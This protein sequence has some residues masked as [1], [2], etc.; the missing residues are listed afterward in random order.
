MLKRKVKIARNFQHDYAGNVCLK[1][2]LLGRKK[3][4]ANSFTDLHC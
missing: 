2:T 4:I 3:W 1:Q